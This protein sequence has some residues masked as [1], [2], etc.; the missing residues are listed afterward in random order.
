ME[1]QTQETAGTGNTIARS[2]E[3]LE[4]GIRKGIAAQKSLSGWSKRLGYAAL[5]LGALAFIAKAP[6]FLGLTV[7]ATAGYA[8]T[9]IAA[10]FIDRNLNHKYEAQASLTLAQQANK[11]GMEPKPSVPQNGIAPEFKNAA[12]GEAGRIHKLEEKVEDLKQQVEGKP[13]T[14]DKPKGIFGRFGVGK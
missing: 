10:Y 6:V 14:L 12:D 4:Q 8:V 3:Q 2:L 9:N 5:G 1:S 13:A 7:L 11:P